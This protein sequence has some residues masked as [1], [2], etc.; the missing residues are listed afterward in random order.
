LAHGKRRNF[1][2]EILQG[3]RNGRGGREN[4]HHLPVA[5][6]PQIYG[7]EGVADLRPETILFGAAFVDQAEREGCGFSPLAK[8]G[9]E[10]HNRVMATEVVM[11]STPEPL[12]VAGG[13]S[14][15]FLRSFSAQV[16]DWY[17]VCRRLSVWEER[18]LVDDP[19]PED[20]QEHG[21]ILEE[22]EKTGRWLAL[23]TANSDYPDTAT[24][25]LV[26]MTLKDLRDRRALWHGTMTS[27]QR[28]KVLG[29]VFG[30]S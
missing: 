27:E 26:A 28:E 13:L 18:R 7:G 23:V 3:G 22:L 11:P 8:D 19:T 30:E 29:G 16:E 15:R 10:M 6:P 24:A 5:S 20:F 25:E 2:F 21:H 17:D 12:D 4:G 9:L 14:Q 1:G